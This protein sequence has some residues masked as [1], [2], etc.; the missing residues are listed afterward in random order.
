LGAGLLQ[1][2]A[3]V[4][5]ADGSQSGVRGTLDVAIQQMVP[6]QFIVKGTPLALSD[7]SAKGFYDLVD[8]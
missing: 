2:S 3:T 1:V 7:P 5:R 4:L 6:R 8:D